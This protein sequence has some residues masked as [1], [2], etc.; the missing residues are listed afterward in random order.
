MYPFLI[1]T[2]LA[3]VGNVVILLS[4]VDIDWECR[5]LAC[6]F[7]TISVVCQLLPKLLS[8]R[9][10]E[11]NQINGLYLLCTF[12]L[13]TEIVTVAV[14]IWADAAMTPSFIIQLLL[15]TIFIIVFL[16]MANANEKTNA[17]IAKTRSVKSLPLMEAKGILKVAL[18]KNSY[19]IQ[20]LVLGEIAA[21]LESMPFDNSGQFSQLDSEILSGI[22]RLCEN[23]NEELKSEV[24]LLIKERKTMTMLYQQ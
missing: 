3:I 16:S 20:Q 15:F 4:S 24:S 12:Y 21:E 8:A 19:G 5:A 18:C 14:C 11:K 22:S 2:L 7:F 13:I 1:Y 17:S 23:P 10:S 6:V 9:K